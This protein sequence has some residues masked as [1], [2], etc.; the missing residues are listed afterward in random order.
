MHL[1]Y[2]NHSCLMKEYLSI[3]GGK[4]SFNSV[5]PFWNKK[6]LT[7]KKQ[8]HHPGFSTLIFTT[9]FLSLQDPQGRLARAMR[10]ESAAERYT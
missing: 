4:P 5:A 7:S 9:V 2:S 3:V 8:H 6:Q 1:L 10:T